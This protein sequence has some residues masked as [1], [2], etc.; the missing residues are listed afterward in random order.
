M[1]SRGPGGLQ[2]RDWGQF[3]VLHKR[4]HEQWYLE[5]DAFHYIFLEGKGIAALGSASV[6]GEE[7]SRVPQFPAVAQGGLAYGLWPVCF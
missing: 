4:L 6:S 1:W 5:A 2:Q 7:G 3:I